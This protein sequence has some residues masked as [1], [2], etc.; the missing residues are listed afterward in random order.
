M[1]KLAMI[2]APVAALFFAG[3]LLVSGAALLVTVLTAGHVA[4]DLPLIYFEKLN[5]TIL[6]IA[7]PAAAIIAALLAL[8]GLFERRKAA[9]S[10]TVV[11]FSAGKSV[12]NDQPDQH[13][14]AA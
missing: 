14:K 11:E 7:L 5:L 1:K 10:A 2:L 3:S 9:E 13:L 12:T 8:P 6:S 4:G